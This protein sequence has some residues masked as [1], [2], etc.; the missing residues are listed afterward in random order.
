MQGW[1]S[2]DMLTVRPR[3]PSHAWCALRAVCS[4]MC[5]L[6]PLTASL[7]SRMTARHACMHACADHSHSTTCVRACA[8]RPQV[9]EGG[10]LYDPKVLDIKE[11]D[12]MDAVTLA[13]MRVAAFSLEAGYPTLASIP[14]IV[15]NG[16]KNVLA[17][18]VATDYDFPLSEKARSRALGC[19]VVSVTAAKAQQ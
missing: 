1:L 2:R 6:E 17:V 10:A 9:Y 7:G 19:C 4:H 3:A 5:A 13:I 18:S 11:D 15:V 8:T 12:L 14:H 16:Y